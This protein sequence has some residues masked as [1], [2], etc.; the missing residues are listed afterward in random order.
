MTK[1]LRKGL[2]NYGDAAFSLFHRKVFIKA[3]GY[4][5]D[6]LDRPIIGVTNTY[7]DYN[8]CHG[9][10]PDLIE[11][12]KRGVLLAGG[13]P[14]VFPTI[15]IHESFAYPTSMFLRNLMAMDTEEMIRAQ[16]M[17]A[18]VVIGGC[19]KTLPAQVMAT[20][21]TDIPTVVV[22]TGPMVVGHHRGEVLGACTDCRRLWAQYRAG[23][24]D[25]GE[26]VEIGG[27]LAP[28]VGFCGVMGTASTMACIVE[29]MGLSLPMSA[30]APAP[31][32]DRR[33]IAE[34][35]GK[36]AAEIAISGTPRPSGLITE[37]SVRNAMIVLQAIGGSTNG[38]IHLIAMAGRAGVAVGL[39]AF[40][41]LGRDVPVLLN[42]KP[43]GA[44]YM[45]HFH[46]AGGLP[47][48]MHELRQLLDL[49]APTITGATI[50]EVIAQ[51]ELAPGQD[52]IS[53]LSSPVKKEGAMAVLHGNLAPRSAV[54]KQSAASPN[55]MR[56]TGR[57]VVF[58][59]LE[60][61]MARI[62]LPDLDV[63]ADDVL[64]LRNAGPKGAPGMPEAGYL[65]I[66]MKL[67]REG[68]KDMVRI[69]DARM[70][71]TAFGTIV[72]H[73]A[74]EAAI[75]GP[76]AI[77]QTGDKIMLDVDARKIE[78]LID[79]AELERRLAAWKKLPPHRQTATRGYAKL[80]EDSVLQ[81]DQGCD[82]DFLLRDGPAV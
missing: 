50:G 73:I 22:P 5:D 81:A 61:M 46:Y 37:A 32:A 60:D 44:H 15:S 76:L 4:S 66:P 8:P 28:S 35:S 16:P 64:V 53:S 11:S 79:E 70:S 77:V 51:A 6:A 36:R 3:M 69:S 42:L 59:S 25:E 49:C 13:L 20:A 55:L 71:G 57:A 33:R 27:R 18:V 78:L 82:F 24:L 30:T 1:G 67:A 40:D 56:H 29:A 68:V 48:L 34:A 38:L 62:D 63:R 2:T 75:G 58:D 12:V 41:K 23:K 74:P 65:P 19:D 31:H 26:M 9:N 43:S 14:M 10:V 7:S 47:A 72:L 45:E 52:V 80:F 21:S 39:D 54:I 17:D